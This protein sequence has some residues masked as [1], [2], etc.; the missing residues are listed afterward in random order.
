MRWKISN[1]RKYIFKTK[2]YQ[3]RST[4]TF[5]FYIEKINLAVF[6]LQITRVKWKKRKEKVTNDARHVEEK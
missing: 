6:D 3:P 5:I 1:H 2:G 4:Y